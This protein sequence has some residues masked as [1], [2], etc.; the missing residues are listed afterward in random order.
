MEAFGID[1]L[2]PHEYLSHIDAREA[3]EICFKRMRAY[4]F[5]ST[6]LGVKDISAITARS[7]HGIKT[8]A[9]SQVPYLPRA[10]DD[11][12]D[13]F[14]VGQTVTVKGEKIF[15]L[16][17]TADIPIVRN[18]PGVYYMP[19]LECYTLDLEYLQNQVGPEHP[20]RITL[21]AFTPS[22]D[23]NTPHVAEHIL[24]E[25]RNADRLRGEEKTLRVIA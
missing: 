4:M 7:M 10:L 5:Q 21:V 3:M 18:I 14:P 1:G 12:H 15:P 11:L 20:Y 25:L 9:A 8:T 23:Y 17:F 24:T 2:E 6:S 22:K 13:D 16:P 19:T